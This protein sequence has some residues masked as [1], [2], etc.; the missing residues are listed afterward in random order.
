M[1]R[2]ISTF[3]FLA[4]ATTA[5]ADSLTLASKYDAVGTNPDGS[6][7]SGT[8]TVQI[9]SD[10]TFAIEWSINGSTYKG[11]G[12]RRNDALAATYTIDG[13]PGLVIYKVNGDGLDGLWAIRGENGNGAEHLTPRQ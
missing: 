9:L 12:M 10:T 6:K 5:S 8:A 11:F 2:A 4:I 7:Y 1:I 13:E 3:A